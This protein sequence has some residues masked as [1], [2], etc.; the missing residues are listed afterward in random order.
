M[1]TEGDYFDAT[2]VPQ[3]AEPVQRYLTHELSNGGRLDEHVE[4]SMYGP[5]KI[6]AWTHRLAPDATDGVIPF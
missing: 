2:A 6:G 1:V 3:L 5:S 4:L